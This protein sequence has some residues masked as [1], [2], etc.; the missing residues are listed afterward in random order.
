MDKRTDRTKPDV[1]RMPDEQDQ[2]HAHRTHHD[3]H[4]FRHIYRQLVEYAP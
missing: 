3:I 2:Q 1:D 4:A